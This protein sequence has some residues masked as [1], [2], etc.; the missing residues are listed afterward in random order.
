M[1]LHIMTCQNPKKSNPKEISFFISYDV[2][3]KYIC[4]KNIYVTCTLKYHTK[5]SKYIQER[6][7]MI[8]NL[9]EIFS[10]Y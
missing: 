1:F 4:T 2:M 10:I 6:I 8:F 5:K 7:K 3:L 9:Y